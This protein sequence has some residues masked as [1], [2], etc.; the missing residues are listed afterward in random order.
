[1]VKSNTFHMSML[2]DFYGELLT[3]KQ[4]ELFDLYYNE[5]LSLTEIAENANIS[6]QGVR[7]A[8]MRSETILRDAE[9]KLGFVKKYSGY[10]SKLEEIYE[11]AAY[12]AQVNSSIRNYEIAVRTDRIQQLVSE[13]K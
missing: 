5:D 11:A 4:K 7:D 8:I 1:M 6:R 10:E 12:I 2:F 3:D 13:M 9:D